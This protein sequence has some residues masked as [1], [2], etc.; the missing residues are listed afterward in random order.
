ML[1]LTTVTVI[2]L[3]T[4]SPAFATI[5]PAGSTLS[6][7]FTQPPAPTVTPAGAFGLLS[8]PG[9][10]RP[11]AST[12]VPFGLGLAGLGLMC[13]PSYLARRLG[14]RTQT[15]KALKE[16]EAGWSNAIKKI[17]EKGGPT[18]NVSGANARASPQSSIEFRG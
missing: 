12:L 17:A 7:T 16:V 1:K 6:L 10:L 9:V 18:K 13:W 2:A 11:G 8:M 4:S 5:I 15:T 14:A 3:L